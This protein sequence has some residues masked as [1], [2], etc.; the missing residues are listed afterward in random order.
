VDR[1]S[2]LESWEGNW[3]PELLFVLRQQVELYRT[4]QEKIHDCDLELRHHLGSIGSKV[5]LQAQPIGPKPK[6]RRAA[7][8]HRHLPV[9]TYCRSTCR[10]Q[11]VKAA[12]FGAYA[13]INLRIA[14]DS[15][16]ISK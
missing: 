15:T 7:V 5:D 10:R 16:R 12:C 8:I 2:P 6:G 13:T 9:L 3:R 11:T 4:Y 14:R 1:L